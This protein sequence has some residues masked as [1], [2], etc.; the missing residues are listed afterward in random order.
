MN[1]PF[2]A[3]ASTLA[4]PLADNTAKSFKLSARCGL[5]TASMR[6]LLLRTCGSRAGATMKVAST[7]PCATAMAAGGEP[8]KGTW[9]AAKPASAMKSS[10]VK[11]AELP[12]PSDE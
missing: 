10:I 7:S 12:L 9:V 1:K 11:W 5:L 6:T 3:K 2:Q 4:K 8:L